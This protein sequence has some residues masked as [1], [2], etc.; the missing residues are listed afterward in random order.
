MYYIMAFIKSDILST[1]KIGIEVFL[2]SQCSIKCRLLFREFFKENKEKLHRFSHILNTQKFTCFKA[3]VC[4]F[5]S[6]F[7]SS[8]ND[9]PFKTMKSV[10][11]FI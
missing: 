8:P 5:V 6:N 1:N 2:L 3:C 10:F 7:Y 4:Y 9:S 11:Y